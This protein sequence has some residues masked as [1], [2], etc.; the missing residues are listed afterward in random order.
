MHFAPYGLDPGVSSRSFAFYAQRAYIEALPSMLD[1]QA[2]ALAITVS[3]DVATIRG[4]PTIWSSPRFG[5][6]ASF[7]GA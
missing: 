3:G 6:R 5:E 2:Q 4:I 1:I 7:S